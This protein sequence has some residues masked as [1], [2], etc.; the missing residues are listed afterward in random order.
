MT[1]LGHFQVFVPPYLHGVLPAVAIDFQKLPFLITVTTLA[2]D[3]Y[4][5]SS[6]FLRILAPG[7]RKC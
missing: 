2:T 6:V 5:V 1:T 7:T 4:I 3:L